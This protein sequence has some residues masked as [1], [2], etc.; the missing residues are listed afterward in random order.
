MIERQQPALWGEDEYVMGRVGRQHIP[1]TATV[2]YR[3]PRID[4][5]AVALWFVALALNFLVW[6]AVI[7]AVARAWERVTR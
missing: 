1:V 5:E 6:A 4:W 7:W 3:E 2:T